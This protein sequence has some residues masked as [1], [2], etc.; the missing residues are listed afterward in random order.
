MKELR[1]ISSFRVRLLLVL[2]GLLIVTLGTQYLLNLRAMRNN[3]RLR[4]QQ[5]QALIA[6]VAL[7]AKSISSPSRLVELIKLENNPLL[8]PQTGRVANVVVVDNNWI[9]AD[10]LDLE[11]LQVNGEYAKRKLQD[12]TTLPPVINLSQ[13]P[14]EDQARFPSTAANQTTGTSAESHAFAVETEKGRYYVIVVLKSYRDAL[15]FWNN[16]AV[17]PLVYTLAVLL[18]ATIVVAI[19]VWRFTRPIT[20]LS[21]AAR[22]VAA[23]DFDFRVPAADR[24]DEMGQLAFRFNEMIARLGHMRELE[25]RL[26][27]AEQSAVVG[28]LASAI[29]H[30]I[31]NPLNYINLTLDHLRTAYAP[32]DKQKRETFERLAQQLKVEV[33]R[34]NTRISEFLNYS[35]PSALELRPLDLRA[36][37]EDALRMVEVK[38]QESGIETRVEQ[39]GEVP[40]VMGDEEALRSVFTNLI[41]NSLQAI[42]GDGGNLTITISAENSGQSARVEVSDTGRGISPDDIAK[43]FEPYFSTKD[44]GTGL[45]LAIV[46][47]VVDDHGWMISVKSKQGAGTTFTITLPTTVTGEK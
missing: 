1:L 2:A 9:V 16:Q 14:Q 12:I 38:A 36:E 42:D 37:A 45:G 15:S 29:A 35:R 41:I 22:R 8:D 27:Q 10:S 17:R 26:H 21:N 4:E 19:L 20:D 13:L 39:T 44:T 33:A 18:A 31:R 34:I 24:S 7:G 43:V 25:G 40:L 5:Q 32:E 11:L 28:R 3:R 46:K 30:E 6:G 47:K 23:G